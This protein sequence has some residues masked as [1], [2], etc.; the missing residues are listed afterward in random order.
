MRTFAFPFDTKLGLLLDLDLGS[1][2]NSISNFK[3]LSRFSH[4]SQGVLC[5]KLE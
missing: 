1:I 3:I 2:R 4:C 5:D